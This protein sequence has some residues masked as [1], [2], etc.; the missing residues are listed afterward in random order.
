MF[1]MS[2]SIILGHW[3]NKFGYKLGDF[4][5]T[6]SQSNKIITLPIHQDLKKKDILKIC[7]MVNNFVK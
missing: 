4:P 6:E 1:T 7:K 2:P 5:I 3:S